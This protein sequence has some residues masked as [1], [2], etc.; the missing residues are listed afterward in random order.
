MSEWNPPHDVDMLRRLTHTSSP[1]QGSLSLPS[2]R[3]GDRTT[4]VG[5]MQGKRCDSDNELVPPT[6]FES[7]LP[8]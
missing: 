4:E 5:L 6:E 7:V 1:S 3:V 2:E 8:A